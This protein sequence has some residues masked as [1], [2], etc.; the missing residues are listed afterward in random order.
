MKEIEKN[1]ILENNKRDQI[2]EERKIMSFV[3]HPFIL[4]LK[5]AF[6]TVMFIRTIIYI[7][8]QTFAVEVTFFIILIQGKNFL[9]RKQNFILQKYC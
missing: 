6:Q 7:S 1:F 3:D 5:F 2:M 9:K 4:E 8:L